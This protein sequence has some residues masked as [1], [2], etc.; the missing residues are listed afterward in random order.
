MPYYNR[1]PQ[2]YNT[3]LSFRH[4]HSDRRRDYE[5]ILVED[6]KGTDKHFEDLFHMMGKFPDIQIRLAMC[7]VD[8]YN[9]AP[10]Y[11]QGAD[12]SQGE[13]IVL[14]NPECAHDSDILGG[15][16]MMHTD[17]SYII[18]ACK[19]MKSNLDYPDKYEDVRYERIKGKLEWYQHSIHRNK[20]YH[21]CTSISK[22]NYERVG[23]FDERYIAGMGYDDDDFVRTVRNAGLDMLSVDDMIVVH[24]YH[25]WVKPVPEV[26]RLT[27][28]NG[29]LYNEKWGDK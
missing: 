27:D 26:K 1:A 22:K 14:T 12:M 24:Q 18:C 21:F 2:L 5:V 16:D 7:A 23:G 25:E 8:S 9:P 4:W 13:Y 29:K 20:Q 19:Y 15:L 11:N 3:L 10:Q 17:N 28:I 6:R